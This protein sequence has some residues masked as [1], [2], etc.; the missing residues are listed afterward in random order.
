MKRWAYLVYGASCHML[1]LVTYAWMAAFV[2][3]LGFRQLRTIDGAATG[4]F[5]GAFTI[6]A[7]LIAA[8]AVPHSVMARPSF[9]QWWTR[10]IPEPIER[11]TYVLISCILMAL[12]LW[13]WRPIGGTVWEVTSPVGRSALNALFVLGWLM[14]PAISLLINHFDLFGTRQVWLHFRGQAYSYLPFRTPLAYRFVRHP[15]YV[16]WMVAFWAT[17]TMTASHLIFASLTTAYMLI[18]IPFEERDLISH[19][20]ENYTEYRRRVSALIPRLGASSRMP[21]AAAEVE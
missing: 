18:A 13:Y 9:K 17:P 5:A 16:G 20:G 7:L 21:E 1:F 11:S 15:L 14:V 4:S 12:V 8:F 3:N 19:F 2:G 10:F 6:D